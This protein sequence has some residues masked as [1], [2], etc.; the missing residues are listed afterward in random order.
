MRLAQVFSTLFIA[1]LLGVMSSCSPNG[2]TG[3]SKSPLT[4]TIATNVPPAQ[5]GAFIVP[6][7][8]G[9]FALQQSNTL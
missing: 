9:D 7:L 4:Y 5:P 3:F 6:K 1:L 8:T 2:G